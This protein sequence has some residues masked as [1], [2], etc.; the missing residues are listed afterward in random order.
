MM[1][2]MI[3]IIIIIIIII[4]CN[5]SIITYKAIPSNRSYI[6]LMNKKQ[7]PPI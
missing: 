4:H 2:M 6:T 7:R 3:I 1:M 5:S